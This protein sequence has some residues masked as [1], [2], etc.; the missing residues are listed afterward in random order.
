MGDDEILLYG[1]FLTLG[2]CRED[3]AYEEIKE[4]E[5]LKE[6]LNDYL[7]DYNS[8]SGNAVKL[9]FFQD[10]VEHCLRIARILRGERG[11]ALLIGDI[12]KNRYTN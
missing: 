5:K 1:D 10:A 11:N 3:R 12:F 7:E 6:I 9:I 8:I 2:Q 4:Y